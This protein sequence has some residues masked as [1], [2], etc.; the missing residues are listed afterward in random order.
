MTSAIESDRFKAKCA[1]GK[2]YTVIEKTKDIKEPRGHNEQTFITTQKS[3]FLSTGEKVNKLADKEYLIIIKKKKI[4]R[5]K[6]LFRK[7]L[8]TDIKTI[9][10]YLKN[11]A[12]C[13]AIVLAIPEM[14]RILAKDY[15]DH[16]IT[17]MAFATAASTATVFSVY[18][19]I[20][21]YCTLEEK[22]K[23]KLLHILAIIFAFV[24]VLA[25]MAIAGLKTSQEITDLI[26]TSSY[27]L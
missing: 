13:I 9:F 27:R 22:P 11:Q 4:T 21:F 1:S 19:L 7:S 14:L 17:L 16:S 5:K 18:N 12:L 20:W 2:T 23:L 24:L 10:D 26:M 3:Y 25:S 15:N 8:V 6:P